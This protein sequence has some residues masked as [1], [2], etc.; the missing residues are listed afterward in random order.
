MR[1]GVRNQRPAFYLETVPD[2]FS[3]CIQ[4]SPEEWS[5][6]ISEHYMQ[7]DGAPV[8]LR[9]LSIRPWGFVSVHAGFE[10]GEMATKPLVFSGKSLRLNYSTSAA[11][12][13][14][15][16][17]QDENGQ[18][19]PGFGLNDMTPLFGDELDAAITWGDSGDL[20]RLAGRPVRLRFVLK[21]AD[22]FALRFAD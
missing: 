15:V 5:I 12:S 11:G 3:L 4:S 7:K 13:V 20:S 17:V 19:I 18:A 2:T 14:Q 10:G 9:R 1:K 8:R 21:D 16:E 6:L 22:V